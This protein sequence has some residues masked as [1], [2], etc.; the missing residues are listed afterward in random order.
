M[1][2]EVNQRRAQDERLTAEESIYPNLHQ[3]AA[4]RQ[5]EARMMARIQAARNKQSW[6]VMQKQ[7]EKQQAEQEYHQVL[8]RQAQARGAARWM[9]GV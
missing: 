4:R 3:T 6:N 7:L 9:I 2:Q 8:Q 1:H 5:A